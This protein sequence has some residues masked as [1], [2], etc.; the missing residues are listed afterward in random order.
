MKQ[1]F[2]V[3]LEAKGPGGAWTFMPI[4]FDVNE[5]FGSKARIAVS[6]KINGFP[7]R[8]SL[9][10]EG[11]STHSMMVSKEIQAGAKAK[12][13]DV[14]KVTLE[15]DGSERRVDTPDDLEKALK[16]NKTAATL[17]GALS[18]SCKK[19]Y[20]DWITGAK[21]EATRTNRIAKAVEML[22]SGQ[23]RLR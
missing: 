8:N 1:T 7:F 16:K 12:A 21:Q 15:K 14:V 2:K 17:F 9:M 13:G 22:A 10:P 5:V 23:K 20:V 19:E 11:D 4:P 18:Y 3:K 6:G